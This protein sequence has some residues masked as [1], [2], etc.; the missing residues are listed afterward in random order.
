MAAVSDVA[1]V[2]VADVLG[3][4]VF[5]VMEMDVEDYLHWN[6][7]AAEYSRKIQEEARCR[8]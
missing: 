1:A 8:A 7:V 6:G 3:C 2:G 4:S 5:E